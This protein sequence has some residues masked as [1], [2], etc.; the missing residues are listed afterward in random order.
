M[1]STSS[2]DGALYAPP[3]GTMAESNA[4]SGLSRSKLS[5]PPGSAASGARNAGFAAAE[6]AF[7]RTVAGTRA[8]LVVL[9]AVG[10]LVQAHDIQWLPIPLLLLPY[11]IWTGVLLWK[12]LGGWSHAG[13]KLYPWIDAAMLLAVSKVMP[14]SG[15]LLS[16]LTVLPVVALALIGGAVHASALAFVCAVATLLLA[17]W[18]FD[19]GSLPPLT[20][21]APIVLLAFG[22]AAALIA[23]PST[24]LRERLLL[25]DRFNARSDPRQGLRHHVDVLLE[26]IA[27]H[28]QLVEATISLQ[29]PQPRV[30]QWRPNSPA[31]GLGEAE[32][33]AWRE[34][35][36][37]LP[38]DLGCI[39]TSN[40]AGQSHATAFDLNSGIQGTLGDT[41]KNA[42]H[43][44]VAQTMAL[45]LMS[46]GQP[47]GHLCLRRHG[48]A[49]TSA[50]LRWLRDVMRETLPL[51]ER[52]DL[53]EQLQRETASRERERIGRDLHDSA[54]Q[55]YLGLKYGL[56]A[57]A[58]NAGPGNPIAPNI[59]EL[60]ELATQE[61]DTLRDVVSGL[62]RGND[63]TAESAS[64]VALQRQVDRFQALYGLKVNVFA[65]QAPH[66][67]GSAARAV[68]HMVNEALT[69]VRR[70]T[71]ATSVTILFDVNLDDVVLRLR[72]DHGA[73]EPAPRDFLPLSLTERAAEFGGTVTIS[74]EAN[75]T[76]LA[77]TLPLLGAI[78]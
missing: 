67:R 71:T 1:K 9:G 58:R 56:E 15:P 28:F 38:R 24:E 49:F 25:L 7:L 48:P 31:R 68:L 2:Q 40:E 10:L 55:P 44:K 63:P 73:N 33:L 69:N 64:L 51:L 46:Y 77:I 11:V 59:R 22:P 61:L 37:V 66:L 36:A 54:V 29:G 42:L 3:A 18:Q 60:L 78:G 45:P 34:R 26:L 70:H 62:R 8:L 57:L 27:G 41:A 5:P 14:Q 43:T 53:L 35:L 65:P 30:I 19:I 39:C 4:T 52:S 76:E 12:T 20:L 75:F 17:S 21:S 72:N 74:H 50:D 23:R 6:L 32:E 13:S 16:A 47:L